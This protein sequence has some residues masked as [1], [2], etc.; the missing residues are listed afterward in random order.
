MQDSLA[1]TL[2]ILNF[3]KKDINGTIA[4]QGEC[5]GASQMDILA[6]CLF[7]LHRQIT[8]RFQTRQR[9]SFVFV[10]S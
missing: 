7:Y 5:T 1:A 3:L 10:R 4:G 2:N 6:H 8:V 9:N